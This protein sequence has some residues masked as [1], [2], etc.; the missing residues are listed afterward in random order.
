MKNL[1]EIISKHDLNPYRYTCYKKARIIDTENGSFVLKEKNNL[2]TYN[3]LLSRNFDYFPRVISNNGEDYELS[4]YIEGIDYPNEQKLI[5][6]IYVVSILHNKTLFYREIDLNRIKEIYEN[7]LKNLEELSSYYYNINE[8]I[9]NSLYMSP[10]IYLLAKNISKVYYALYLVKEY[11]EKWYKIVSNKKKERVVLVHNNLDVSHII[12]NNKEY[13]ISWD[14]ADKD[15]PIMDLY[16]LFKNNYQ[17]LDFITLLNYYESKFQLLQEEK[18]LLLTKLLLPEK[19]VLTNNIYEDT[20]KF[21][22]YFIFLNKVL[23]LNKYLENNFNNQEE[24][25]KHEKKQ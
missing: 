24:K 5:D 16:I 3:Y 25:Q 10:S 7:Y 22:N 1:R 23:D 20:V 9:D 8:I 18:L 6:L 2:S 19:L 4:E 14:K 12:K 11:L 13:L 21:N 15:T 17:K